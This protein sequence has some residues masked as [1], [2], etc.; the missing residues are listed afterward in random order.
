MRPSNFWKYHASISGSAIF[1]SSDG[2]KRPKPRLSQRR[3]PLT[4]T[5]PHR[6]GREQHDGKRVER[7]RRAR[8]RLRRNVRDDPHQRHREREAHRLA[9]HPRDALVGCREERDEPDAGNRERHAQKEA[10]DPPREDFPHLRQEDVPSIAL[11][12]AFGYGD[13]LRRSGLSHAGDD[14]NRAPAARWARPPARR[15]RHFRPAPRARFSAIRQAHTRCTT[16]G[17]AGARRRWPAE[18]FS[19]FSE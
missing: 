12:F 14:S 9:P 3:E 19:P 17:R 15:S 10:V 4:V 5:P 16:R 8:D 7:H 13:G 11:V 6:D 18:Y 2:W 1:I